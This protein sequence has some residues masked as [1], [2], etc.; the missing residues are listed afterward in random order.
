MAQFLSII[1]YF[2]LYDLNL[3]KKQLIKFFH[4]ATALHKITNSLL[5]LLSFEILEDLY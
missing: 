2:L 4:Y 3:E 5:Y 1:G